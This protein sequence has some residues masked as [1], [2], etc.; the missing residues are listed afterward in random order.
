MQDLE[1]LKYAGALEDSQP[2]VEW[3]Y[4]D[5]ATLELP[6]YYESLYED[7]EEEPEYYDDTSVVAADV[8]DIKESEEEMIDLLENMNSGEINEFSDWLVEEG[9]EN[10]LFTF[11]QMLDNQLVD[12]YNKDVEEEKEIVD[13]LSDIEALAESVAEKEQ[14]K[15]YYESLRPVEYYPVAMKREI[16]PDFYPYAYAVYGPDK[17]AVLA[18]EVTPVKR[19]SLW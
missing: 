12:K 17:R 15:A 13:V 11:L 9:N 1:Q 4:P 14:Q 2:E 5:V 16:S 19:W 7:E 8:F 18:R 3:E 6:S 10:Y